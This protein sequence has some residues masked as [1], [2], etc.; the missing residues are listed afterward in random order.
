LNPYNLEESKQELIQMEAIFN[1]QVDTQIILQILL[2]KGICTREE[3]KHHR[4]QVK[5]LSKY[6][7]TADYLE[8]AKQGID[9]YKSN[10]EQHLKDL[11]NAKLNGKIK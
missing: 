10:P 4:E 9:Y 8:H 2:D 6:K 7:V 3:I 5:Q 11:W 1:A